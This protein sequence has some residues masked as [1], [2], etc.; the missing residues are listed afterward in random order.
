MR[1]LLLGSSHVTHLKRYIFNNNVDLQ[2]HNAQIQIKMIGVNGGM[3]STMYRYL[4]EVYEYK[5]DVVILQIGS[6]DLGNA[7]I[8]V[9]NVALSIKILV[10]NLFNLCPSI[11][12]VIIGLVFQRQKVLKKRGLS[13]LQYN[14]RVYL[15]NNKLSL[16]NVHNPKIIFWKH[17]GLQFPSIVVVDRHGVHL[18]NEGNRRFFKS[19]RGALITCAKSLWYAIHYD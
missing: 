11:K 7:N 1:A 17:R 6:N 10:D 5:P 2:V 3:V 19:L 14:T 8:T 15:L 4:I 12:K 18:N 13:L 9:D 16:F